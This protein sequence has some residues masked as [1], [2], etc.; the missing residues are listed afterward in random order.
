M[1]RVPEDVA[2]SER[3]TAI[4]L[5]EKAGWPTSCERFQECRES[6]RNI[7][8]AN[9]VFRLRLLFPAVPNALANVDC[10]AVG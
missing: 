6:L 5:K 8:G 2:L 9:R 10:R 3:Q 7:N 1:E 4:R